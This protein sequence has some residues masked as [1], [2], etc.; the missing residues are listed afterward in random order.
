MESSD[1]VARSSSRESDRQMGSDSGGAGWRAANGRGEAVST[2]GADLWT[3]PTSYGRKDARAHTC[4][5]H[6]S[7]NP[8]EH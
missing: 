7:C 6:S 3:Q 5:I 2:S 4:R 8:I 1:G